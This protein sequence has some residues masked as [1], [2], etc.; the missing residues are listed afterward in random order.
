MRS[1]PLPSALA[2]LRVPKAKGLASAKQDVATVS[3]TQGP[4]RSPDRDDED[5]VVAPGNPSTTPGVEEVPGDS[6]RSEEMRT[7]SVVV[8]GNRDPEG[9]GRKVNMLPRA[10]GLQIE[11]LF[12]EPRLA[13]F[14]L[15]GEALFPGVL[16]HRKQVTAHAGRVHA[17]P[18]RQTVV[19]TL[20]VPGHADPCPSSCGQPS[21]KGG[22]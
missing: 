10:P 18:P 9:E 22:G 1:Q 12:Q 20:L 19:E 5:I 7:V 11:G 15:K 14:D 8:H 3:H 6:S 21:M 4:I 16:A 2:R 17:R 13:A